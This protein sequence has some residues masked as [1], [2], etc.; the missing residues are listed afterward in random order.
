[1]HATA[2]AKLERV[3]GPASTWLPPPLTVNLYSWGRKQFLSWLDQDIPS[4]PF[5][6]PEKLSTTLWG[7]QFRSPLF[8]AAG[9][10]KN[11]ECYETVLRQGA[12]AYLGGTGT[13]NSRVGNKRNGIALPIA[14]YPR[15]G[16][17]SN[18]LGLPND[19]DPV[20]AE[21]VAALPKIPGFPIG[22]SVMG[23]PDYRGEQKLRYLVEGLRAYER[24][25]VDFLEVNESC[26][27][28]AHGK[29]QEDELAQRL[30]Y[31]QQNF[32][33][34]RS[35]RLPVV[36][37]FSTDT[38]IAQVP[39]LVELLCRTG[40]DGVNFGNT[41]TDYAAHREAIHPAERPLYDH[42]TSTFGGG[43][44][45][46]P[47]RENSLALV[48]A[49]ADFLA[50]HPPDQEFHIIRTGGIASFGDVQKSRMAGASLCQWYTG[51]L[52]E[53]LPRHG[54]DVYREFWRAA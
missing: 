31:L 46:K 43:I 19:G 15:S 29:P 18:W 47:L 27:N 48:R 9:M 33:K 14:P 39:T 17:A 24:A 37:K 45:G 34:Q 22:W 38:D 35:R 4:E 20:N 25:R 53:G 51:Y 1:M 23:S 16:G 6:P 8:N 41:S 30:Q 36:V 11:G 26:P 44:S 54:H 49:A 42:F 10:F 32:L 13:W 5:D 2:L 7:I 12:G 3:I 28:T 52:R 21:R 50:D 40:F